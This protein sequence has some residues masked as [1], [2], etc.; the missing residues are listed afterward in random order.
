M[1]RHI[2][3]WRA[4]VVGCAAL[5]LALALSAPAAAQTTARDTATLTFSSPVQIPG[6]TLPAGS[7]RFE[8]ADAAAARSVVRVWSVDGKDLIAQ[9]LVVP[10][11]R[12]ESIG[13]VTVTFGETPAGVA[14]A[15][16]AWFVPGDSSGHEFI[17]PD[18]QAR[19]IADATRTVVLSADQDKLDA[20][21]L[22]DYILT[23]ID[24]LG[25]RHPYD[26]DDVEGWSKPVKL[27]ATGDPK[28]MIARI[29]T[30][31]EAALDKNEAKAA[32]S[33][34]VAL[35]RVDLA[36]IQQQ[37]ALLKDAIEAHARIVGGSRR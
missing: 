17:Y 30:I 1:T 15:L 19:W 24:A 29:E 7:Y 9:T 6:K 28:A 5:A 13:D 35:S 37:L 27:Q 18:S 14:P 23:R 21:A 20:D 33:P 11:K 32:P 31:L 10:A 34:T 3:Q 16:K 22:A 36:Q 2:T 12:T 25:V 26:A 8:V 4:A